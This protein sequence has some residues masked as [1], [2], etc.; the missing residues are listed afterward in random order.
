MIENIGIVIGSFN[1]LLASFGHD[2]SHMSHFYNQKLVT[3]HKRGDEF[4][5]FD[6]IEMIESHCLR[7]AKSLTARALEGGFVAAE[8]LP[9]YVVQ[10]VAQKDSYTIPIVEVL[11]DNGKYICENRRTITEPTVFFLT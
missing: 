8:D 4:R 6:L 5:L 11:D 7:I 10:R 2:M 3:V 1:E 9:D